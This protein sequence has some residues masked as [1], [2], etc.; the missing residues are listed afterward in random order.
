MRWLVVLLLAG[1]PEHGSGG[2]MNVPDAAVPPDAPFESGRACDVG[3]PTT[4][5]IVVASPALD[6]PS[7]VCLR[8]PN[9]TPDE[10]TAGCVFASDCVNSPVSSCTAGYTCEPVVSVGPFACRSFCVCSDRAP[11]PP[12]GCATGG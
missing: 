10:C 12:A 8:I 1:C 3:V 4:N 9:A 11:P 6:C 7:R 5:E 2:M